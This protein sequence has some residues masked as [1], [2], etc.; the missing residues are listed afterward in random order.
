MNRGLRT[1]FFA[2]SLAIAGMPASAGD[3]SFDPAKPVKDAISQLQG[4]LNSIVAQ[5]GVEGRV[6]MSHALQLMQILLDNFSTVYADSLGR[7]FGALDEEQ[8]KLFTDAANLVSDNSKWIHADIQDGIQTANDF[9]TILSDS[10]LSRAGTIVTGYEPTFLPPEGVGGDPLVLKVNGFHLRE[11]KTSLKP[12]LTI[13]GRDYEGSAQDTH[14]DFSIP[15]AALSSD[16]TNLKPVTFTL[17]I[18]VDKGG[19]WGSDIQ[20]AK[21]DLLYTILPRQFGSYQL[22]STITESV[23][24]RKMFRS[25]EF[26]AHEPDTGGRGT[27]GEAITDCTYPE[28]GY[29]FVLGTFRPY[30]DIVWAVLNGVHYDSNNYASHEVFNGVFSPQ[31]ICW[32][33]VAHTKDRRFDATTAGHFE[34]EIIETKPKP[35]SR[36][37]TGPV[38]PLGWDD[39]HID[40]PNNSTSVIRLTVMDGPAIEVSARP[41]KRTLNYVELEPDV[42]SGKVFLRPRRPWEMPWN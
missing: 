42:D 32:A 14:I 19:W 35:V 34:I 7:A 38:V 9:N 3:I 26:T 6:T 24:D 23:P 31:L 27:S 28:E 25:R 17:T 37:E 16:Q 18:F 36:E 13:D 5:L 2:A 12:L 22:T 41:P 15:R 30:L 8:Q 20:P 40:L 33:V 4:A 39:M 21:Y 11:P 29:E 10:Y 1:A